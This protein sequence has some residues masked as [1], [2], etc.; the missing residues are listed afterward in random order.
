MDGPRTTKSYVKML[1]KRL[2]RIASFSRS[3]HFS[4]NDK[5][6]PLTKDSKPFGDQQVSEMLTVLEGWEHAE[7][8][9][10]RR[11]DVKNFVSGVSFIRKL[12]DMAEEEGHH[13]G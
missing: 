10:R 11:F 4:H 5:C 8:K 2:G 12:A 9:I 6:S 13:P 3:L 7:N 1:C